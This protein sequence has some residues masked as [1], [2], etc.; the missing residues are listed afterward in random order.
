[1]PPSPSPNWKIAPV[2]LP[3]PRFH[4]YSNNHT[5]SLGDYVVMG[6]KSAVADHINVA[7]RARVA[8]KAG[9]THDLK[10]AGDYGGFPAVRPRP[11]CLA[12]A[13]RGC[14]F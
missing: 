9:V 8:A 14:A 3:F 1:M 5:S 7:S 10:E 4:S 6:G 2:S 11:P 13:Q 12:A